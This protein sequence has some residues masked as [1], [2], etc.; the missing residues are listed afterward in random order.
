MITEALRINQ[1]NRAAAARDLGISYK[2]L[3][4]W[5]S[6]LEGEAVEAVAVNRAIKR[7]LTL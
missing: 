7:S 6:K 1:G 2:A 3:R 4:C 5:L